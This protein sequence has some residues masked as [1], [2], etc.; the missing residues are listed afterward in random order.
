[1]KSVGSGSLEDGLDAVPCVEVDLILESETLWSSTCCELS[2]SVTLPSGLCL[3]ESISSSLN[4]LSLVESVTVSR[5]DRGVEE[6]G[7]QSLISDPPFDFNDSDKSPL[8]LKPCEV[9]LQEL[10]VGV[11]EIE[12]WVGYK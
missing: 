9:E 6:I 5:P 12:R 7:T 2:E 8:S 3:F 1:M 4:T 10:F 11:V